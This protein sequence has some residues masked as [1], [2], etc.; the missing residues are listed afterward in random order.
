M[1]GKSLSLNDDFAL[2]VRETVTALLASEVVV[3][4][5]ETVYGVGARAGDPVA[6]ARLR[7]LKGRGEEK[8]FQ[9]LIADSG[10]AENFGAEISGGARRLAAAFWPGPLTLVVPRRG[11]GTLGLRLP[12]SRFIRAVATGI[13]GAVAASSANPAGLPPPVDAAGADVFGDRVAL[14]VDGGPS[15]VGKAS[16]VV[17]AEGDSFA[18]LREGAIGAELIE[19]A[20]RSG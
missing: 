7:E 2:A 4:P 18:I 15:P 6:A 20:W 13:G 19:R 16:S 10:M 11:G 8:P 3:F 5:T 12:D 1:A 14:L 9:L 17:Q